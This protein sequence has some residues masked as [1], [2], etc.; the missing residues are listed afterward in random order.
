MSATSAAASSPYAAAQRA[1]TTNP[2]TWYSCGPTARRRTPRARSRPARRARGRAPSRARRGSPPGT[3]RRRRW[4]RRRDVLAGGHLDRLAVPH[5]AHAVG[6]SVVTC[7]P[8]RSG[9]SSA[10]QPVFFTMSDS[11]SLVTR[12]RHRRSAAGSG[13]RHRRRAAGRG[14]RRTGSRAGGTPRCAG[15]SPPGR[16]ARSGRRPGSPTRSTIGLSSISRASLIAPG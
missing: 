7:R 10:V 1:S 15:A 2:V 8:T 13:H 11:Y 9:A 14:P 6:P 5:D 12:M 16:R 3:R 4:A